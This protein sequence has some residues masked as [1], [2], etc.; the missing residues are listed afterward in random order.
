MVSNLSQYDT[1]MSLSLCKDVIGI[2]LP[3]SFT[4]QSKTKTVNT[5]MLGKVTFP[6][7]EDL[8]VRALHCMVKLLGKE[9][10]ITSLHKLRG[11]TVSN[12]DKLLTIAKSD[13]IKLLQNLDFLN[14]DACDA[15]EALFDFEGIK[16]TNDDAEINM[17][18]RLTSLSLYLLPKLVHITRMVPKGIPV[19]QN[20]THL[21]VIACESLRYL[22]SPSIVNSLV[23]LVDLSI[24]CCEALEEIIGRE[25]DEKEENTSEKRN[26]VMDANTS[27]NLHHFT[28]VV[29]MDAK[30]NEV[31]DM[32]EFPKLGTIKLRDLSS[33]KSFRSET[34]NDG[35][36]QT[37]F[38][39]RLL[40]ADHKLLKFIESLVEA[41]GPAPA[42]S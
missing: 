41:E 9:M 31:I 10:P 37:L 28:Q 23:A 13:S 2:S 3:S 27:P 17:L 20:L 30:R 18:G 19:F 21:H 5:S 24:T 29:S 34:N 16:V 11:M 12:C 25:E 6:N 7:M 4:I 40:L 35:I 32:L 33:F 26:I 36:L 22:F 42:A 1:L 39:Q 38:N 15:L 8:S 14:V